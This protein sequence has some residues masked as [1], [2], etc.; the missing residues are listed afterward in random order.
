MLAAA[1][2]PDRAYFTDAVG[3][4]GIAT[5]RDRML[6]DVQRRD[7]PCIIYDRRNTGETAADYLAALAVSLGTLTTTRF[8]ILPQVPYADGAEA[9]GYQAVMDA[10]NAGIRAAWPSNTFS[11]GEEAAFL[12]SLAPGSTRAD[13][14][15]RNDVGQAIEAAAIKAWF[16][17]RGW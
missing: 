16:D 4:Q 7:W 13:G 6:A 9:A 5:L 11:A 3:G 1:F 17:A 12:A 8:L 14:L 2:N 10:I 15:H